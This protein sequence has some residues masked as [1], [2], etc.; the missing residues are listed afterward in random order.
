MEL[1]PS[2]NKHSLGSTT[3]KKKNQIAN[4]TCVTVGNW[5]SNDT[6]DWKCD[7]RTTKKNTKFS[8]IVKS[9]TNKF[10]RGHLLRTLIS[11]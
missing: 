5:C 6:F 7:D 11:I 10:L 8:V 4:C 2:E 1:E 3:H 9:A